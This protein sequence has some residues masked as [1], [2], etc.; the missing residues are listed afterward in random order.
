LPAAWGRECLHRFHEYPGSEL[1]DADSMK[2]F[3]STLRSQDRRLALVSNGPGALQKR[4]SETLALSGLFDV[5][6]FCGPEFPERQKPSPWAWSELA[7]WRSGLPA[8]YVGDD[9]VDEEF[10]RSGDAGFVAFRFR[11][12]RYEY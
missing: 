5:C 6:V 3:L 11:S 12:P 7:E 9:S 10:A 4:K 8:M 2:G 1:A